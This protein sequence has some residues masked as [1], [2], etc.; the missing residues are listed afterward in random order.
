MFLGSHVLSLLLSQ[1]D[2]ERSIKKNVGLG[3]PICNRLCISIF[4]FTLSHWKHDNL[5]ITC[6]AILTFDPLN[7][8]SVFIGW[9]LLVPVSWSIH[10][11]WHLLQLPC[12]WRLQQTTIKIKHPVRK[13]KQL[14]LVEVHLKAN[15]NIVQYQSLLLNSNRMWSAYV[16][17]FD[18][19]F[20]L[21]MLCYRKLHI[22]PQTSFLA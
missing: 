13:C 19:L 3:S 15:E 14:I 7:L 1:L 17:G 4:D 9:T 11:I 16:S 21:E 20:L 12:V 2:S 6:N 10:T 22:S 18:C 5:K 8:P